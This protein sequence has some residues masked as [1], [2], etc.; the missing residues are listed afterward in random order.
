MIDIVEIEPGIVACL[1][2][3]ATANA[4]FVVTRRGLVVID[5]LNT[6][7]MGREL[8]ALLRA[9][10][11]QPVRLLINTHHHYDHVFGNQAFDA[12]VVAHASL[13][14]QLRRAAGRDLGPLA[15][16]AWLSEHPE[17]RWLADELEITYPNVLFEGRL[18]IDFPP[19][20]L[21]VEHL[22]GH[23]P[24]S[25]IVYVPQAGVVFAGDLVFEGRTPFLRQAHI[26]DTIDALGTIEALAPRAIVPGHGALC[27]VAYV[28]RLRD[29]LERLR[30][31]VSRLVALGWEKGEVLDSDELPAWWTED[32]PELM[33]QNLAR[34]YDEVAGYP[35]A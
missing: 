16:A 2:A 6:P 32:R 8:A 22:G 35:G 28:T 13:P 14:E 34:V 23:T 4:G 5:A 24:D 31:A 33:R 3:N 27:D 20:T 18:V 30:G 11:D 25:S 19:A 17:D 12:P 10:C 9:R 15:L 7:A 26:G 29:Y 1:T 21:V